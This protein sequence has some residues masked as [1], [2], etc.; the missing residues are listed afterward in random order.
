MRNAIIFHG[1]GETPESYWLPWLK[2][3]LEARGF[4]VWAP[5][6]PNADHPTVSVQLPFVL[7]NGIFAEE[8][9]LVGHS[10]GCPLALSVLENIDVTVRK[11]ILVSGF[12]SPLKG[13]ADSVLQVQPGYD[14]KKIKSHVADII[15]MNSDNDP[16]GCDDKKGREMFDHLGGTLIIRHGEGHM[17]S[18][19]F[20]QPYKEFP[21]LA[22][23][24]E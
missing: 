15:F 8:T 21:L 4:M 3:V 17:G 13:D 9:V 20:N 11:A 10:A 24:I 1:H 14:W 5:Q 23:L 12:A 18:Q 16:W 22:T 19:R 7:H 2:G 6:L